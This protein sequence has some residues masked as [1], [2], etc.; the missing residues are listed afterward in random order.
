[1]MLTFFV[2]MG[3]VAFLVWFFRLPS[4]KG[5]CGELMVSLCLKLGLDSKHYTVLNN[6][7]IP[8]GDGGTTQID[9]IVFSPFG[10]FVIETKNMK[11]WIFGDKNDPMWM[12]QIFKCKNQ[13]QNPFRQNYKHI[14]C[15]SELIGIEESRFSH[16]IAFVGDCEIKTRDKLPESLVCGGLGVV[17]HIRKHAQISFDA[18]AI[19]QMVAILASGKQKNTRLNIKSHIDHVQPSTVRL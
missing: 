4:T 18:D 17:S 19:A 8:D 12:Q 1:M 2:F 10:V 9:H 15:L 11:G 13:F 3:V 5:K 7:L 16:I 14:K 6:V